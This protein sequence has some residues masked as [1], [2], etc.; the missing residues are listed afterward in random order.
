M[1]SVRGGDDKPRLVLFPNGAVNVGVGGRFYSPYINTEELR[2]DTTN[3]YDI[4][5]RKLTA[6]STNTPLL[7]D[8]TLRALAAGANISLAVANNVVTISALG[9]TG[10]QGPPGPQGPQGP[11]GQ[12][13][14]PGESITGPPG[15]SGHRGL[16]SRVRLV[17]QEHPRT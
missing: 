6:V 16:E 9:Q 2:V 4:F 17:R 5:Q 8:T 7:V 13:G 11:A 3:V 1:G 12:K 15:A 14:D 10:P